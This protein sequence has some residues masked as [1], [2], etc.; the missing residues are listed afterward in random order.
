M[1][2]QNRE[3]NDENVNVP[4]GLYICPLIIWLIKQKQM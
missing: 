1:H 2:E 4:W 3:L